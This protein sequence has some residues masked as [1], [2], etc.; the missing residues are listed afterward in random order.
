MVAAALTPLGGTVPAPS[1]AERRSV[2][3]STPRVQGPALCGRGLLDPVG[4]VR[5][6]LRT[7]RAHRHGYRC[8]GSRPRAR[9]LRRSE[10]AAR[11]PLALLTAKGAR[12]FL[13]SSYANVD[14]ALKAEKAPMLDLHPDDALARGI[15]DGDTVRVFNG[16]GF[17]ELPARV[18][19]KVR[20]RCR[21]D[22]FRMVGVEDDIRFVGQRPDPGRHLQPGGR[23]RLPQRTRRGRAGSVADRR[24]A[25][26][27]SADAG[28]LPAES[29]NPWQGTEVPCGAPAPYAS[30]RWTHPR[31][32]SP[33]GRGCRRWVRHQDGAT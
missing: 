22:A 28:T 8:R 30:V 1:S 16:S 33:G 10:L 3:A 11:Y 23:R 13:N 7:P 31:P 2:P 21:L 9:A 4:Q 12:H 29:N 26:S 27:C 25:C 20:F 19:E 6:V 24:R 18:S 17:I 5:T 15:L 32:R 14:R